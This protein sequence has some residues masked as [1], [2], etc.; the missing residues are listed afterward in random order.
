[1]E[2]LESNCV[3]LEAKANVKKLDSK[4]IGK[5][6]CKYFNKII[7]MSKMHFINIEVCDTAQSLDSSSAFLCL[8]YV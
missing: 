8:R 4:P 7:K 5:T 3:N 2:K 1:M 6:Q